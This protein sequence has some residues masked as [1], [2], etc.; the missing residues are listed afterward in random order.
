[1]VV[2]VVVIVVV[3]VVVA[4]VVVVIV[5]VVVEVGVVIVVVVVVIVVIEVV[6]FECAELGR[7][8][9]SCSHSSPSLH[10]LWIAARGREKIALF[11]SH[12]GRSY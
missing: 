1:M 2:V 7:P 12:A 10:I 3:V 6:T 4:L 8:V 5:V 9:A 11:S